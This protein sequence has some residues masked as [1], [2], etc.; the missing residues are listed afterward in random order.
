MWKLSSVFRSTSTGK[1]I[2]G[3]LEHACRNVESLNAAEIG[4]H[5]ARDGWNG[6]VNTGDSNHHSFF[7]LPCLLE[8]A[9]NNF[10]SSPLRSISPAQKTL[11]ASGKLN[12]I[13]MAQLWESISSATS[14]FSLPTHESNL[15][16]SKFLPDSEKDESA[17]QQHCHRE[18]M[19]QVQ[20]AAQHQI[21]VV[22]SFFAERVAQQLSLDRAVEKAHELWDLLDSHQGNKWEALRRWKAN[23]KQSG[24]LSLRS[25]EEGSAILGRLKM[26][27]SMSRQRL[28]ANILHES[29][30]Q[31]TEIL[32]S[33]RAASLTEPTLPCQIAVCSP[34]RKRLDKSLNFLWTKALNVVHSAQGCSED[35]KNK[36][37]RAYLH[38]LVFRERVPLNHVFSVVHQKIDKFDGVG[39]LSTN[40]FIE[41]NIVSTQ[42]CSLS[43]NLSLFSGGLPS[44]TENVAP[45]HS[46]FEQLYTSLTQI[47]VEARS[48]SIQLIGWQKFGCG[49]AAF[50]AGVGE[51]QYTIL[52]RN[53]SHRGKGLE[54]VFQKSSLAFPNFFEPS[55]FGPLDCPWRTYHVMHALH[56]GRIREAMLM[57][58]MLSTW[59]FIDQVGP[60][61]SIPIPFAEPL[62][63]A[64]F[65]KESTQGCLR[66]SFEC[67]IPVELQMFLQN[68]VSYLLWN[69]VASSRMR[70]LSAKMRAS[71][72][73]LAEPGDFAFLKPKHGVE[74]MCCSCI[75]AS[76]HALLQSALSGVPLLSY[77]SCSTN[78]CTCAPEVVRVE[79]VRSDTMGSNE[80][81][82]EPPTLMAVALP[83]FDCT[84]LFN[85]ESLRDICSTLGFSLS[86]RVFSSL[87]SETLHF[88]SLF[89]SCT[90][91]PFTEKP[92]VKCL[93][94]PS[95]S[96]PRLGESRDE[97]KDP[98]ITLSSD[99]DICLSSK[100]R[101]TTVSRGAKRKTIWP[102]DKKGYTVIER[103][104]PGLLAT[105]Q[106]A[107]NNEA[108]SLKSILWNGTVSSDAFLYN[109]LREI[110]LVHDC[111][112]SFTRMEG[113][114]G[115]ASEVCNN[116][117]EI[118]PVPLSTADGMLPQPVE[119]VVDD[120]APQVSKE[121]SVYD[122]NILSIPPKKKVAFVR[123]LSGKSMS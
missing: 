96:D 84:T 43:V 106:G 92:W 81:L 109:M 118:T 98:C 9:Q 70:S 78:F 12:G 111:R 23:Y 45:D 68:S 119:N 83:C 15:S 80:G 53:I 11:S 64:V 42:L 3:I 37:C 79:N 90:G 24:G 41:D 101:F 30:V 120:S 88:R 22:D 112:P 29:D 6:E 75:R 20:H 56:S 46:K 27:S 14:A 31:V 71:Y 110:A 16:N 93:A 17:K 103:L 74:K 1:A 105:L 108:F 13:T 39:E 51:K 66:Q 26:V 94:E 99:L 91:Y 72:S 73:S 10:N 21:P 55:C 76:P 35:G 7:A 85:N 100:H 97:K 116:L 123:T 87:Q 113:G 65:L 104:S 44:S 95:S 2:Q 107:G 67:I 8:A 102:I 77:T 86:L 122:G 115:N 54:A 48:F 36:T 5:G 33:G 121:P 61:Q 28:Q 59:E 82:S 49:P 69:L 60:N 19:K 25:L 89:T 58:L 62:L 18:K 57:T 114:P 47:N 52:F 32:P 50:A 40:M 34:L 4:A 38:F 117:V 63:N